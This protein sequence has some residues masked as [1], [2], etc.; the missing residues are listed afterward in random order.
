MAKVQVANMGYYA[1]IQDTENN[2][3]GIWEAVKA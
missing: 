1:R 2:I 3:I